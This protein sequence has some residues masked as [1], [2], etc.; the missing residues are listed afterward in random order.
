MW[1]GS[2]ASALRGARGPTS[3]RREGRPGGHG[4]CLRRNR[5]EGAGEKLGTYPVD[6][7][8]VN[9][10]TVV[11]LAFAVGHPGRGGQGTPSA[12]GSTAGRRSV[13][14]RA[15]ESHVHGEGISEFA[16]VG[17]ECQEVAGE[18]RR[19]VARSR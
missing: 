14:V 10:G 8:M 7:F 5:G 1:A 19:T 13:V 11:E 9:V 16:V 2:G 18:H 4:E 15:W 6:R 12:D 17:L 3:Q